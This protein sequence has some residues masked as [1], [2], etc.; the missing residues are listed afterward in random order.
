MIETDGGIDNEFER[1]LRMAAVMA[2]FPGAWGIA[3]GWAIDLFL[4]KVTREHPGVKIAV[5]RRDQTALHQYLYLNS[6]TFQKVIAPGE[7]QPWY[8]GDFI[9]PPTHELRAVSEDG[10]D[11][12]VF[13][14]NESL[15]RQWRYRRNH[16]VVCAPERTIVRGMYNVPVL[17]PEIVLLHKAADPR[18]ED[19]LDLRVAL[20]HLDPMSKNWLTESLR[21]CHPASPFLQTIL[22]H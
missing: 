4:G 8:R 16:A 5:F 9:E 12:I 20:D 18:P 13:F 21:R 11:G 6:W 15:G 19:E 3:G 14:L 17:S 22:M 10:D 1:P 7:L 2:A